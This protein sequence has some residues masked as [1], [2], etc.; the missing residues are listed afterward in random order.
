[1]SRLL[2][3]VG[4]ALDGHNYAVSLAAVERIVHVVEVAPL[5][6]APEIVL[7]VINFSG[8]II[9]VVDMRRR[10]RL[11]PKEA[12]LYDHLIVAKTSK[13]EIAFIADDVAGA[14]DCPETDI[15]T[16]EEIVPGL[17]YLAGVLKLKDG[18]IFIHDLE[19][20]LSL[21]EERSLHKAMQGL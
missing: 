10:F 16:A 18:L 14:I 6:K 19:R 9:P 21:D 15:T 1:M 7:G 5:P 13:R 4:F 2:Q 17:E 11:P 12:G 20:F 8:R 3:M